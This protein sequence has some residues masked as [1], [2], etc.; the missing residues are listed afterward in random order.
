MNIR[1]FV[2]GFCIRATHKF[3][4]I[5][6][7]YIC[8]CSSFNFTFLSETWQHAWVAVF[9]LFFN[10]FPPLALFQMTMAMFDAKTP[11]RT[12]NMRDFSSVSLHELPPHKR[13]RHPIPCHSIHQTCQ[14]FC[15][16]MIFCSFL[17]HPLAVHRRGK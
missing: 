10:F 9:S 14:G 6:H 11:K 17:S 2:K 5:A 15:D 16:P 7:H 8:R 13:P 3:E 4:S 1:T 12:D